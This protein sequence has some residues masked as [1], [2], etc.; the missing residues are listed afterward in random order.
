MYKIDFIG[1]KSYLAFVFGVGVPGWFWGR[2][3]C[4]TVAPEFLW[5]CCPVSS[6][7]RG[8][9]SRRKEDLF[10]KCLGLKQAQKHLFSCFQVL[11]LYFGIC[12]P[13]LTHYKN[14]RFISQYRIS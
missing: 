4:Q 6:Q 11:T 10:L 14:V 13:V 1:T 3:F 9:E 5:T 12:F 2:C 7:W 8:K